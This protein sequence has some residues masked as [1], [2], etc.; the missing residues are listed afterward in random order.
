MQTNPK[1]RVGIIF[2]GKSFE[3]EVSIVSANSVI[4]AADS[5]KFEF[6]PIGVT[7]KGAWLASPSKEIMK[8]YLA[9]KEV[10]PGYG[11]K[12]VFLSF[13]PE[14]KGLIANHD[15]SF[16]KIDVF[17]PLIHGTFGEDGTLQGALELAQLPYVGCGVLASSIGM[18]KTVAKKLF[19]HAGIDVVPY[20]EIRKAGWKKDPEGLMDR[21][22]KELGYPFFV[23]PVNSGSSVGI[24]K[25]KKRDSLKEAIEV[26]F[27][28]DRKVLVEEAVNAREIEVSVLGNEYPVA[29]LP[30]EIV[31]SNEFY[32][33]NAKYVD[34]ASILTIPAD[35]PKDTIELLK[36]NAVKAYK[37]IDCSGMTRVD[38]F[39]DKTS[40]K[41]Y[42]NEVN[43]LPGFTDISMY[44]K[45]IEASG[46]TYK[47]LITQLI[48]LA[49]ER[50][51]S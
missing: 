24:S 26:A 16:L 42:L 21:I 8:H 13:D 30:G 3:H 41:V 50:F 40:G 12:P 44:P 20:V 45:L 11:A 48:D 7:K 14:V 23:K 27:K 47:D 38:F 43:T 5:E 37:A 33:Y 51:N 39:V 35:L 10:K 2:G 22:E 32:D 17:F 15:N 31:P 9:D 29:S 19:E 34:G 49:L 4:N 6:I 1:L 18:D 28:Y 25:A 46:I 36:T